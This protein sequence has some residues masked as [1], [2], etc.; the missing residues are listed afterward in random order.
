MNII[1]S[2]SKN[3]IK[4]GLI[5]MSALYRGKNELSNSMDTMLKNYITVEEELKN[6]T[7]SM[8]GFITTKQNKELAQVECSATLHYTVNKINYDFSTTYLSQLTDDREQ[9]SVELYSLDMQ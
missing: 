9:V 5:N 6:S 2:Q 4:T 1:L 8:D 3:D 7:S